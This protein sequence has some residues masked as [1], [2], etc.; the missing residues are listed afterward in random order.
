MGPRNIISFKELPKIELHA[1]LDTSLSF[2]NVK[3]IL[4]DI[5]E[6][7]YQSEYVAPPVCRDLTDFLRYPAS[8]IALLQTRDHLNKALRQLIREMREDG[9]IYG[10]VR[11]APLLHISG[12]LTGSEVVET[13]CSAAAEGE[14]ETGVIIRLLLCTLRH[15]STEESMETAS[16]VRDFR[17]K[18]VVGLDLA[19]DEG[20]SILPH[21]SAFRFATELGISSTAHAGEARGP[22]SV[23]ETLEVLSPRRIGHGVRSVEDPALVGLLVKKTSIWK[24]VLQVISRLV[25]SRKCPSTVSIN[26]IGR[27]Y[28]LVSIQMAADLRVQH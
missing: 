16:L 10:E 9:V 14:K 23:S 21:I 13:L 18:G 27:V 3:G 11:F 7:Q 19:A 26:F 12:G 6:V 2:Y 24:F 25:Y 28:L 8:S 4:D 20:F 5:T 22:S 1:H 17:D 15:Y